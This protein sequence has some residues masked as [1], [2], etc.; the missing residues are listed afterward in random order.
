MYLAQTKRSVNVSC[1]RSLP[2]LPSCGT[3][4]PRRGKPAVGVRGGTQGLCVWR[5]G[6]QA[7]P[8]LHVQGW[9][10]CI[11]LS[12]FP[13][14]PLQKLLLRLI[15]QNKAPSPYV[16]T[17]QRIPQALPTAGSVEVSTGR[18]V[19]AQIWAV[20]QLVCWFLGGEFHTSTSFSERHLI[21]DS[22]MCQVKICQ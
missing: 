21:S 13:K 14:C 11:R 18:E 6:F 10:I 17:G 8:W 1:C 5:G 16:E 2:W 19:D 7:L 12:S 15:P 22:L 3:C 20:K 4:C 9:S